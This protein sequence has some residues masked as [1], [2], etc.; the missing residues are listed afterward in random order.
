MFKWITDKTQINAIYKTLIL[1]FQQIRGK[2]KKT[3][4]NTRKTFGYINIKQ[5][6]FQDKILPEEKDTSQYVQQADATIHH[7]T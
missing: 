1:T 4:F 3:D 2:H 6:R 7:H 5:S